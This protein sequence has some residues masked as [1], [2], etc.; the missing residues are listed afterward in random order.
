MWPFAVAAIA[1]LAGVNAIDPLPVGVFYDDA[2]YVILGRSIALGEGYRYIN[3]PGAPAATHFPPGYPALLALFWRIS[4]T[5]PDN[6]ALFKMSNAILLGG[7]ALGAYWFARARLGLSRPSAAIAAL[8]GTITIPALVLSSAVMS[9][10]LFL[11]I[12]FPWLVLAEDSVARSSIK[13]AAIVGMGAGVLCLIRSH[14]F[15]LIPA[16][17]IVLLIRRSYRDA[18]VAALAG[19]LVI[20][21]WVWWVTS[22]DPL[23]PVTVRGQYGSYSGW[24]VEGV[25]ADGAGILIR[26]IRD[27]AITMYAVVARSFSLLQNGVLDGLAVASVMV[28]FIAGLLEFRTR[29]QVTL[30]FILLYLVSLLIWPFSPLRF[31]WGV[32]PLL[33]TA[34]VCGAVVLWRSAS[35]RQRR[36]T[37]ARV[38]VAAVATVV[39]VGALVFNVQGYRNAWWATVSRTF[40]PRIQ[41]QLAWVNEKT[42]RDDVIVADDEAAVYLYTGR[43]AVPASEFTVSQYFHPRTAAEQARHLA[44]ILDA[45]QPTYVVAWTRSGL[46]AAEVLATAPQAL[47]VQTDTI[48]SGRVY[49]YVKRPAARVR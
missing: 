26:A 27:N 10:V 13:R 8:G 7:V 31:L 17:L 21:P 44:R 15:V 47:L 35:S 19:I 11:A 20:A 1:I 45:F 28:L 42:G 3:L 48:P 2:H 25:R 22:N 34:M 5:F 37:E 24:L 46:D 33:V 14:G 23:M 4:P 18:A 16:L 36:L 9:E 30:A 39:V 49:R 6:I 38:A 41:A 43:R 32:W 12:L 40:A 29:A